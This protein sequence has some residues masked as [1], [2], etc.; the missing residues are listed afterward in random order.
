MEDAAVQRNEAGGTTGWARI[1]LAWSALAVT[2]ALVWA[3]I[4]GVA[5]AQDPNCPPGSPPGMY[6]LP[7]VTPTA[8][9]T[10]FQNPGPSSPQQ[11]SSGPKLMSPFPKVRTAGSY[12]RTKTIFTRVTVRA[13]KGARID[14]RCSSKRCK[15]T[16]RTAGS[17]L[18]HVKAMQRSFAAKTSLTIRVTDS[19]Q[20]GKY[21]EI[22]TRTGRPPVRRDRCL[23][24]GSAKPVTCEG[25]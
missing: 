15:R 7:T 25:S 22:R 21:V 12:T 18:L 24:P 23:E 1:A 6:C 13:P 14:A 9:G 5:T 2:V 8:T 16:R 19:R 10:P 4:G 3:M 20:I 17:S 11:P